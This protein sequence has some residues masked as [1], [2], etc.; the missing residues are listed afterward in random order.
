MN[1]TT[2][3]RLMEML[4]LDFLDRQPKCQACGAP[5]TV[6]CAD[7]NYGWFAC[8]EHRQWCITIGNGTAVPTLTA[9]DIQVAKR[10]LAYARGGAP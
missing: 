1:E 7:L 6:R 5:A 10:A 3:L 2:A 8:E 4:A 9:E